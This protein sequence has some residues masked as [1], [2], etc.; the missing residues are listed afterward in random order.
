[1]MRNRTIAGRLFF[2]LLVLCGLLAFRAPHPA[3]MTAVP[4]WLQVRS[5]T[6]LR[7]PNHTP[8]D[9]RPDESEPA[10]VPDSLIV[11][12]GPAIR[13]PAGA[14]LL[15]TGD[16]A[17]DDLLTA[18]R[19][20]AG[21]VLF[22]DL[23][24]DDPLGLARTYLLTLQAGTDVV[25]V[26][27]TLSA[28]PGIEYA[29]PDYL[30]YPAAVPGDPRYHEQWGLAA[31]Q[32]EAAWDIVTG[33]ASTVIAI[34]DGGIDLDHAEFADRLWV[35]PGEIPD[36]GQDDDNNGF[37]DDVHGWDF[38]YGTN[39]PVD[40]NGHG[41]EVAGV[42][43]ATANNGV[44][45]A[46]VCWGCRVMVV[47]VMQPSGIANYSDLAAGVVYAA[48]KGA[49]VINISLGG[50]SDSSTLRAAIEAASSKGVIVGGAGNDGVDTLFYP[51]AYPSVLAVAGTTITNTKTAFSNYGDWVDLAAPAE[52]ILTT[53]AGGDW[54]ATNGTSL[55]APFVSGLAGLLHSLHPDWAPGLLRSHL[56]QTAQSLAATDS[57]FGSQMGAGLIDAAAA[58][59]TP[60]PALSVAGYAL[61]D[62]VDG[63]P[64]P[65][66][67]GNVLALNL[68][69][70]WYGA[71]DVNGTLSS[72]EPTVTMV[73][74]SADF[75]DI[76][77]GASAT[78][79][80]LTF[81]LSS[82][83]AYNQE[84]LFALHLTANDGAYDVTLPFTLTVRGP[85]ERVPGYVQTD[86]TWSADKV[87][88]L[89][90]DLTVNAGVTLTIPA[91]GT[92]RF[93]GD[94]S[95][96]V[97]GTLIADGTAEQPIV[98][99]SNTGGRWDRIFFGD[100][101]PDALTD[102]EG[103]Y[104]SGSILRH[105][106]MESSSRGIGCSSATPYLA[107]I[108]SASSG[109]NCV[110]GATPL[111]VLDNTLSGGIY[112]TLGTAHVQGNLL[113]GRGLHATGAAVVLTNTVTG[114]SLSIGTGRLSGNVVNGG[115][116]GM[117]SYSTAEGNTVIGGGI[118][119]G[120]LVTVT[121]NSIIGGGISVG[122]LFHG[123][124]QHRAEC[125]LYRHHRRQRCPGPRQPADR[126][127]A[128]H[129][130]H[131]RRHCQQPD[132]R[133]RGQRP[134]SWSRCHHQ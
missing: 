111:W 44:G 23:D 100:S 109:I 7:A 30:A 54:G 12:F 14:D 123:H 40:E 49:Q 98:F 13:I 24:P 77:N 130:R 35:N 102:N 19:V 22:P 52:D 129:G 65:A 46:G 86:T 21:V 75:G 28:Y 88:I 87:Y 20:S 45:I 94:Y 29:E 125:A 119:A 95:L 81:D 48:S 72:D 90:S 92:V 117:G 15:S 42:A 113:S 84:S 5:E 32:A 58:M 78:G 122:K 31:I 91:G 112:V 97:N 51:A 116:L 36:N 10:Y 110:P 118:S 114:A 4:G 76:A 126:Q 85:E 96:I 107:H 6:H 104:L 18:A 74:A 128:G 61:N 82:G 132:R 80:A 101:S 41:T 16:A 106:T 115:S 27:R 89:D 79:S 37:V 43:A 25:G 64:S 99:E 3:T 121:A 56:I 33:T 71:T 127:R 131:H 1:M 34:V 57:Q 38:V 63:R 120:N 62:L 39:N 67:S 103:N 108:S 2:S 69:N 17:L 70:S 73:D 83:A 53:F 105:V 47:K 60:Q 55:A 8:A 66:S 124:Q 11:K 59:Q 133:Q 26:A 134:A 50:Y 68:T 9:S 93:D